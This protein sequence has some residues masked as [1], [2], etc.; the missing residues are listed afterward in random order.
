MA[1]TPQDTANF[2]WVD[3]AAFNWMPP[4]EAPPGTL[5]SEPV[6][7]GFGLGAARCHVALRA[8]GGS[9]GMLS[10]G[11]TAGNLTAAGSIGLIA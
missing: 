8:V 3:T 1:I 2:E 4:E 11:G 10:A 6:K 5:L 9:V 7:I